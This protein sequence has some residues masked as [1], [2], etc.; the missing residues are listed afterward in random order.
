MAESS[1]TGDI[2]RGLTFGES[3]HR[4]SSAQKS[5]RGTS[6]YLRWVNRPVG[7]VLA[8]LAN[9]LGMTPNQV[10]AVSSVVTLA[11][12]A[13]LAL[14]EPSVGL[15]LAVAVALAVG[16]ALD[17]A[18]GQLARLQKAFSPAGE[19]LDHMADGVKM[20]LLHAAVAVSW[21]RFDM[22]DRPEWGVFPLVFQL[23][24]VAIF[25]GGLLADKLM[26][27]SPAR[28]EP[29]AD[30]ASPARSMLLL[31]ADYGVICWT[32]VLLGTPLFAPV[33]AVLAVTNAVL[34]VALLIHWFRQ[35]RR[36]ASPERS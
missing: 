16:F 15:G 31:P 1:P 30:R 20:V 35:L 13:A 18:D 26:P 17:S 8:A 34:M 2:A 12:I 3:L 27:P 36:P 21:V 29:Q 23:S 24:A 4:L 7:R 28:T 5:K 25:S 14:V 9:S 33:Y 10:T 22:D 11:A 32:F 6:F 19:W